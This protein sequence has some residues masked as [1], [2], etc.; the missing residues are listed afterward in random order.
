MG[1]QKKCTWCEYGNCQLVG[2]HK[3]L[4]VII[5]IILGSHLVRGSLLGDR[6]GILDLSYLLQRKRKWKP[7]LVF[8]PREFHGQRSLVG[9]SPWGHK[10][11]DMTE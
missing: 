9:S 10:E 7:P 5:T 3:V 6:R 4:T 2:T 8:L 1:G 11:S